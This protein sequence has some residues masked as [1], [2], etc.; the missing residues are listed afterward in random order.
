[1]DIFRKIKHNFKKIPRHLWILFA[2]IAVGIFLRTYNFHDWLDFRLDQVRDA[3]LVGEVV[4]GG[5]WPDFGPSMK[6]S[7]ISKDALFHVGPIYY[8][9]QIISAKIFGDY[10]DKMA[11]PD[12]IFSILSIPL[13]YFFLK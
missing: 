6:K 4:D 3:V 8:H 5:E 7:G 9:F 2:I 12:L 1:M 10:P 11:Y 13:F